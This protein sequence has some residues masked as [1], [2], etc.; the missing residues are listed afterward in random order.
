[1][2]I[3]VLHHR[4]RIEVMTFRFSPVR[5]ICGCSGGINLDQVEV[6]QSLYNIFDLFVRTLQ[7]YFGHTAAYMWMPQTWYHCQQGPRVNTLDHSFTHT[8]RSSAASL[9]QPT[10]AQHYVIANHKTQVLDCSLHLVHCLLKWQS[11]KTI[12][13]ENVWTMESPTNVITIWPTQWSQSH[14]RVHLIMCIRWMQLIS[15]KSWLIFAEI[16]RPDD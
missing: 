11:V 15:F 9:Q 2:I 4:Y 1:M 6:V 5:T 16:T 14:M 12:L 7:L 3:L 10:K 13:L 8:P